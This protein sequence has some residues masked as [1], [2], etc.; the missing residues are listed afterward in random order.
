MSPVEAS[1]QIIQLTTRWAVYRFSLTTLVLSKHGLLA[2]LY[3]SRIYTLFRNAL[4]RSSCYSVQSPWVHGFWCWSMMSYYMLGGLWPT[5][6]E[7]V[8]TEDNG[9]KHPVS[10]NDLVDIGQDSPSL[11]WIPRVVQMRMYR[12]L[13]IRGGRARRSGTI[14]LAGWIEQWRHSKASHGTTHK[15]RSFLLR[16]RFNSPLQDREPASIYTPL[17]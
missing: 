13:N 16:R 14:L 11:L 9:P 7:W 15:L 17:P 3:G 2:F 8:F 6:W 1:S 12:T 10:R 4:T 5:L